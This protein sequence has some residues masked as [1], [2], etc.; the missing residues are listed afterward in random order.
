MVV[1]HRYIVNKL[2]TA[3][4]V[5]RPTWVL[6]PSVSA[7]THSWRTPVAF[8]FYSPK[9]SVS[10]L[11]PFKNPCRVFL[12]GGFTGAEQKQ[13][14]EKARM[15]LLHETVSVWTQDCLNWSQLHVTGS[16]WL[17]IPTTCGWGWPR[18]SLASVRR[19]GT[20]VEERHRLC[21][22]RVDRG[23]WRYCNTINHLR[24]CVIF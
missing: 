8:F 17:L 14:F 21:R 18:L 5:S 9:L 13:L 19:F 7:G 2:S 23:R 10:L 4:S 1:C 3:A 15:T 22:L 6:K 24:P 20:R 12:G 16:S 11:V